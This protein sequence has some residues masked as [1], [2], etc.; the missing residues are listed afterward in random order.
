MTRTIF[1]EAVVAAV[2]SSLL[3]SCGPGKK[4]DDNWFQLRG[5][6]V[7]WTDVVADTTLID[8]LG[9]MKETGMNTISI[10]GKD[11]QSPEYYELKQKITL[12]MRSMA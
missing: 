5:I 12:S 7:A 11:Y 8:W 9:T 3:L 1:R 2:M 10:F 6:V 4:T